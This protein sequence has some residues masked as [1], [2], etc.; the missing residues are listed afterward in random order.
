MEEL[1]FWFWLGRDDE[2]ADHLEITVQGNLCLYD[3][4][5][6]TDLVIPLTSRSATDWRPLALENCPPDSVEVLTLPGTAVN[7]DS[8]AG[9]W[10]L[11]QFEHK[12]IIPLLQSLSCARHT[13]LP[14]FRLVELIDDGE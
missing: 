3:F 6:L 4:H 8:F 11:E 10:D 9:I 2:S 12:K 13:K 7:N 1:K 5:R 14:R